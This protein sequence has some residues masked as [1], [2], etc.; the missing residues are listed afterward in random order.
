MTKILPFPFRRNALAPRRQ[1]WD[2]IHDENIK[3]GSELSHLRDRLV[4]VNQYLENALAEI[5]STPPHPCE[6]KD[7]AEAKCTTVLK[8]GP[9]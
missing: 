8:P 4:T 9:E 3:I 5:F 1:L 6:T 7:D 2:A